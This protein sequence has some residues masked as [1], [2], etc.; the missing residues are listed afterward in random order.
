V[1]A[2]NLSVGVRASDGPKRNIRCLAPYPHQRHLV[3]IRLD[4]V[5]LPILFGLRR[6][7]SERLCVPRIPKATTRVAHMTRPVQASLFPPESSDV[8]AREN[9]SNF[10]DNLRIAVHRWF[11]YS[12]GF[13]A[14]WVR[15]TIRQRSEAGSCR[16]VLDPFAGSGTVLLEAEKCGVPGIGIESHPF[17]ARVANAKLQWRLDPDEFNRRATALLRDAQTRCAAAL[18][19]PPLI[20]KCFPTDV[21]HNL[22]GLKQAWL[23]QQDF[24]G[25]SEL[26]WLAIAAILRE[27]SPVGTA[28]WQY[29]LP[30]KSKARVTQPFVAFERKSRLMADDMRE[31][32]K[33]PLGPKAHLFVNDARATTP[34]PDGS[35]DLVVTSP[36]YANN[37]DYGDATR[38][39][40]S[41][42]G[43]ITGWGDLHAVVRQHL[44]RSCSQHAA[45]HRSE[46]EDVLASPGLAPIRSEVTSKVTELSEVKLTKGGR[47]D[48]D[49]MI[50]LYFHDLALIW[51]NLRVMCADGAQV[52]FVIGDSAPY[53]VH[54]PVD[55]W[56]GELAVGSGFKSY[57]FD[58]TRDRNTKWKNRKHSVP[59]HEGFLWVEG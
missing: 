15:A 20:H 9:A 59:L 18:D 31:R 21:L 42:F 45:R 25:Y 56:L 10:S 12:A 24:S 39:E 47:K 40:M 37:F 4:L 36:P 27:C 28:Q 2:L 5:L 32:Q 29:V 35:V 17:V 3:A 48:Y 55:R 50:A 1:A 38:L 30:R 34:I 57:H 58:K 51:H 54:I 16:L 46:V 22:D 44:I 53:G 23:A 41:F 19:Y 13:S 8:R 33:G 7:C 26:L 14:D 49:V 43:E 6:G 52:C 11:R